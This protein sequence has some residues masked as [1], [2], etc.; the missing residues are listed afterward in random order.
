M[1]LFFSC[2]SIF[3]TCGT[4]LQCLAGDRPVQDAV[5]LASIANIQNREFKAQCDSRFP[6]YAERV[7]EAFSSNPVNS[8]VI[9]EF[10]DGREYRNPMLHAT[11]ALQRE[12]SESGN[13]GGVTKS[14]CENPEK[15]FKQSIAALFM[16]DADKKDYYS[17]LDWAAAGK[18]PS[19]Q[20]QQ[21]LSIDIEM[22]KERAR[23]EFWENYP[24]G[25]VRLAAVELVRL[26][27]QAQFLAQKIKAR[28]N[29]MWPQ[30][31]IKHEQAYRAWPLSSVA[32]TTEVNGRAYINPYVSASSNRW[33][34]E[35][36]GAERDKQEI[37]CQ[38]LAVTLNKVTRRA[39]LEHFPLL[40]ELLTVPHK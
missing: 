29:E 33:L 31:E 23:S 1:R 16:N 7:R 12:M 22:V 13:Y 32:A 9:H 30:H 18:H 4:S 27:Q 35:L 24:P 8:V 39:S 38:N 28:C 40:L 21:R 25:L 37:A 17:L 26:V 14:D 34:S 5:T 36:F 15:L 6:E 10:I 2:L 11:L 3:L 19:P 20:D